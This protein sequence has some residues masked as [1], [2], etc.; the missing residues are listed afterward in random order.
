MSWLKVSVT[1]DNWNEGFQTPGCQS[2]KLA[3]EW[4]SWHKYVC[5]DHPDSCILC[6][7]FPD[8]CQEKGSD[9]AF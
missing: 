4:K 5:V 8:I 9:E 7:F 6:L 2:S 1:A 3:A